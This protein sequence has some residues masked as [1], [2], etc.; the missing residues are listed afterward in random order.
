MNIKTNSFC[1]ISRNSDWQAWLRETAPDLLEDLLKTINGNK[2]CKANSAKMVEVYHA[3][4]QRGHGTKFEDFISRRFPYIVE[5][6]TRVQHLDKTPASKAPPPPTNLPTKKVI[7]QYTPVD[8]EALNK[9]KVF[10]SYRPDILSFPQKHIIIDQP[11]RLTHLVHEFAKDKI[12]VDYIIIEDRAYIE[13]FESR[14]GAT[15]NKVERSTRDI[16]IYRQKLMGHG[17]AQHNPGQ[18]PT[19]KPN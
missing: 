2:G 19:D 7:T 15:V 5:G 4:Y 8:F 6:Q 11:D 17:L 18:P 16:Y 3:L 10:R 13:Y 1:A 14:H 9:H 12:G